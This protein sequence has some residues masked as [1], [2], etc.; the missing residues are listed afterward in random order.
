MR[1]PPRWFRRLVLCPGLLLLTGFVLT[2]LP[3]WLVL[4]AALSPLMP[5]RL[6]PLRVLWLLVLALV[7]ESLALIA[8]FGLWLASGFG[9]A[10]RTPRF[11]YL[12]YQLVGWY[13]RILFPE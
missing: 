6:R 1:L 8:M 11:E 2:T 10:V 4:A 12:H 5:G 3:V 7:L 9:V 13:L